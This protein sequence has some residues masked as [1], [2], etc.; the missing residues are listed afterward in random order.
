[1]AD[2]PI[3]A[4]CG[5]RFWVRRLWWNCITRPLNN[6]RLR[7]RLLP[8]WIAEGRDPKQFPGGCAWIGL[9]ALKWAD[10]QAAAIN[11]E[12]SAAHGEFKPF[13]ELRARSRGGEA[14]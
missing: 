9:D 14:A 8:E 1:M 6:R 12:R 11:T 10:Q 7:E 2:Q 13:A 5:L 3:F 4:G